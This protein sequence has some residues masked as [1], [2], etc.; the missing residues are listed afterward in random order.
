MINYGRS[1]GPRFY[2]SA[3]YGP[4]VLRMN[5]GY[6]VPGGTNPTHAVGQTIIQHH[7]TRHDHSGESDRRKKKGLFGSH[8]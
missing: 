2:G 7:G 5:E 4:I 6:M 3:C 8:C 1:Y